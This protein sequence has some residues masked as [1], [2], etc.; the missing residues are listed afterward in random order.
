[1]HLGPGGATPQGLHLPT[2]H[3]HTDEYAVLRHKQTF[4]PVRNQRYR[5]TLANGKIVTG[6]TDEQGRTSLLIGEMI[7]DVKVDYLPDDQPA[8]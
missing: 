2:S 8:R 6:R 5:V 7:G 4:A 1:V 3:L